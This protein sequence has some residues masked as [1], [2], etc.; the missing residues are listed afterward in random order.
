MQQYQRA[1]MPVA[2]ILQAACALLERKQQLA[3]IR[4]RLLGHVSHHQPLLAG[5]PACSVA[6]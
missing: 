4:A 2:K 3:G 5:S 6:E 1:N